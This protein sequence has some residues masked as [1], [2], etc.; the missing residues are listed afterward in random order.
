MGKCLIRI[1]NFLFQLGCII[2]HFILINAIN[3]LRFLFVDR[4]SDN[5]ESKVSLNKFEGEINILNQLLFYKIINH[6]Y[7]FIYQTFDL[8]AS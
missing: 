2:I 6:E 5:N 8:I 7:Q 1:S 4:P 3:K